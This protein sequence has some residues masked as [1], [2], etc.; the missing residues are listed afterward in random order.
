M[1]YLD[2]AATTQKKPKEVIDAVI[3]ALEHFGNASRGVH[4]S[5]L[6]ADR[7]IYETRQKL[8][9]LFHA[10]HARQIVFTQNATEALNIAINGLFHTGD[11]IITSCSEHNSV[12]RP[13]Y[14]L[15][16]Q[17]I[18]LSYIQLD[19][20]GNIK[21]DTLPSLLQKNTKAIILN[22]ASNVSGNINDIQTVGDFCK[23]HGL[24]FLLDAS[25][26]AGAFDID[27]SKYHI[28]VLCF[29]GHKS[30]LAPQGTGGL[31]VNPDISIRP[32]LV[33]GTGTHTY[34][35][36]Q[37]ERMP[38]RLEAGTKNA[39]AIAGLH[40]SLDYILKHGME[41]LTSQAIKLSLMFYEG[42]K[43]IPDIH[44]YGDFRTDYRAPI[45]SFN[46]G[47]IDS[48]YIGQVLFEEYDIATR[49]G[50]HCAPLVHQSFGTIHQGMVRCSFSH[51][52]TTEE[53]L[54]A[55]DCIKK[56]GSDIS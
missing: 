32:W 43:D 20:Y 56:I 21:S 14:R 48:A 44:I 6:N 24:L 40:A 31:Y 53:T 34:N 33:G 47:E 3:Y 35:K 2:N 9:H 16:S 41:N 8:A 4:T 30:L 45:V 51:M 11:H 18:A 38:E 22:H 50:A 39:H 27:V 13:L 55:I 10:K 19:S 37:P 42:I 49:C 1:V 25:Q 52:N 12:L 7:I 54:Y 29:T 36:N 23:E 28:D 17:N 46:L 15:E 26:T 5:T